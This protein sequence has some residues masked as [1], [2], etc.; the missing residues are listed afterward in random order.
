MDH[1]VVAPLGAAVLMLTCPW[2]PHFPH[3]VE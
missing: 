1:S 2:L 3:L